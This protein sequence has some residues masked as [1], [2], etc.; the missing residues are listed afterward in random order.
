[1]SD[2]TKTG[3]DSRQVIRNG[4]LLIEF[5]ST[6]GV[7]KLAMYSTV[8]TTFTNLSA[9]LKQDP[10][11]QV[12]LAPIRSDLNTLITIL[13]HAADS[14]G[15]NLSNFQD[16]VNTLNSLRQLTSGSI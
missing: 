8:F 7:Y 6:R 11:S 9:F 12:D 5:A 16:V 2:D 15:F 4:L 14:N 10:A 3:I 1:M 13:T